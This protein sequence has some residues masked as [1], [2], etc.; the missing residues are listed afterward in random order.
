VM[1]TDRLEHLLNLFFDYQPKAI[2]E[3]RQLCT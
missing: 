1:D 3:F 2:L